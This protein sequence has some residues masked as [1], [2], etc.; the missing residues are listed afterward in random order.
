MTAPDADAFWSWSTAFY[1]KPGVAEACLDLQNRDG[2]EVN[3]V[4]LLL[5]L[6]EKGYAPLGQGEV[7]ELDRT[8]RPW[9][10]RVVEPLR[11]LRNALKGQGEDAVR[12]AILS[13]ELVAERSTQRRLVAALPELGESD[14]APESVAA[15]NLEA[16]GGLAPAPR[17]TLIDALTRR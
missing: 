1:A 6:A 16:H 8:V 4:L 13:A 5:W 14:A 7:A 15:R 9:R 3:L 10:E 12:R 11:A 2:A 17:A